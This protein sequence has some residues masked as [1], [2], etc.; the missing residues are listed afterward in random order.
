[1]LLRLETGLILA[2]E[3]SSRPAFLINGVTDAASNIEGKTLKENEKFASVQVRWE[4]TAG[5]DLI[6]EVW[7]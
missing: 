4:K 3:S 5:Q 7:M 6:R 2:R 1:M